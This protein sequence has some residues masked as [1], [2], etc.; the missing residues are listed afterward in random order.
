MKDYNMIKYKCK[1]CEKNQI[2]KHTFIYGSGLCL[3]CSLKGRK[4]SKS[5]RDKISKSLKNHEVSL[6]TRLKISKSCIKHGLFSKFTQKNYCIDCG[7][8][9]DK[10]SKRC[11]ICS[12]KGINNGSYKHGKYSKDYHNY[13][14]CG[15]EISPI[16]KR[17]WSCANKGKNSYNYIHGLGRLPYSFEFTPHLKKSIIERDNHI[18]QCC[19]MTQEEHFKKYNR[20]I[21]IHHIDYD[22]FNCDKDNLITLC[23]QCNSNANY[24]RDYWYAFY[25]YKMNKEE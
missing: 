22:R 19:G 25:S 4:V 8:E 7:K 14:E 20:N 9:I 3:S 2:H 15:T 18:C 23:R 17:C 16:A 13:C 12:N 10:R 6:K 1:R 24:N 21:E 11:Q 5:T